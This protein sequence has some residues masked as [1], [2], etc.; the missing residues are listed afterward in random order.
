MEGVDFGYIIGILG[1]VAAM[2]FALR[3]DARDSK[4]ETNSLVEK[5]SEHASES[6]RSGGCAPRSGEFLR[7]YEVSHFVGVQRWRISSRHRLR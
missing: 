6:A 4:Q 2:Y 3:T 7:R 1:T 5:E